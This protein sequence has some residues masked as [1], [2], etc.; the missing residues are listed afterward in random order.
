[1]PRTVAFLTCRSAPGFARDDAHAVAALGRLGVEV[2]AV[3][4]EDARDGAPADAL[5]VTRSCWNYHLHAEAFAR[6]IDAL[7]RQGRALVNAAPVVLENL[8]KR[9]L[10][11]LEGRGVPIPP[12]LWLERGARVSLAEILE[13]AGIDEAV[14]KPTVSLS[15]YRTFRVRRAD[16]TAAQPELDAILEASGAMV[17]AFVP[18][19]VTGGELSLVFF[20]GRYSHAVRKRPRPGDFRVQDDHGGTHAPASPG[21]ASV[22]QA[23][24]IVAT[25]TPA[26]TF[27]RVDGVEVGGR[28]VLMELE[29]I[30][31]VLFLGDAPGAAERF[32]AALVGAM[33]RSRRPAVASP[34]G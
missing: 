1:M 18:E 33:D 7:T 17:Q 12:T 31:P 13:R 14:L 9:Y 5:L 27:A 32:A 10:A 11:A 3:P 8:D 2:V 19:I 25:A 23:E 24:A 26:P 15:A 4:W 28:L 16:A 34:S 21:A 20:D 22:L 30:D 6:Q 29:L